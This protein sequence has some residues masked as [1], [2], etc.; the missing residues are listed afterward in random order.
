MLEEQ[1]SGERITLKAHEETPEHIA[2][3]VSFAKRN[4]DFVGRWRENTINAWL[5]E[6]GVREYIRKSRV[7]R[8][9]GSILRYA[10]YDETGEFIGEIKTEIELRFLG[11]EIGFF[12]DQGHTRRRYTLEAVEI[13][14]KALFKSGVYRIEMHGEEGNLASMQTIIKAG[15]IFEGIRRGASTYKN[16]PGYFYSAVFSKLADDP[17]RNN[18]NVS[19]ELSKVLMEAARF[20]IPKVEGVIE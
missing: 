6:D 7:L 15:Y 8:E 4:R 1:F 20:S 16:R 11:T 10:I 9:S 12:M 3:L 19:E 17:A 5:S 2:E 18:I 13:L 14:E